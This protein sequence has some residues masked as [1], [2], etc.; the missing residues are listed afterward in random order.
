MVLNIKLKNDY[1]IAWPI[2]FLN[3]VKN[4]DESS[5]QPF[6]SPNN[7]DPMLKRNKQN[8]IIR[9]RRHIKANYSFYHL[10]FLIYLD[11]SRY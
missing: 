1:T 7:Y 8:A 4:A 3:I 9:H 5:F 2:N 11:L 6:F 10:R